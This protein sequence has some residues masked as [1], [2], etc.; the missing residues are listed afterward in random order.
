MMPFMFKIFEMSPIPRF[1]NVGMCSLVLLDKLLVNAVFHGAI[2]SNFL[3]G[4]YVAIV[5][6]SREF[7]N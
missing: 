7:G 2:V 1:A 5:T 3:I 4:C 6:N